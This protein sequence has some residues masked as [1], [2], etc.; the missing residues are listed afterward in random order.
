MHYERTFFHFLSAKYFY[1]IKILLTN[2]Q[3][4]KLCF[5]A[6]RP[7]NANVIHK[8]AQY[9]LIIRFIQEGVEYNIHTQRAPRTKPHTSHA[10]CDPGVCDVGTHAH[11]KQPLCK[12]R[13]GRRL[14]RSTIFCVL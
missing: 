6:S 14:Q 13:Q 11:K 10:L 1:I 12:A 7:F 8:Y 2:I 5:R 4:L 3:I 9:A